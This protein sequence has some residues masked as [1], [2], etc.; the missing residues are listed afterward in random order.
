MSDERL[1]VVEIAARGMCRGRAKKCSCDLGG[2]CIAQ[3]MFGTY[4]A[5]A[6]GALR[7]VGK[8]KE[9]S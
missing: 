8:I 7:A 5:R 3:D 6:V 4:A 9:E 1:T 2:T